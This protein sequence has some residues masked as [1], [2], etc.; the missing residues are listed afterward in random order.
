MTFSFV[1]I[2][3]TDSNFFRF[4]GKRF[5]EIKYGDIDYVE[6][7]LYDYLP[8]CRSKYLLIHKLKE[9]LIKLLPF[10]QLT[11]RNE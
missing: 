2:L 9:E 5:T 3:C 8:S 4:G 10:E 1:A 7:S 6:N 11:E